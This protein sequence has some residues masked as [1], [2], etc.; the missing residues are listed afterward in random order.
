MDR[1]F[2]IFIMLFIVRSTARY[3]SS[4]DIEPFMMIEG[5]SS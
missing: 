2:S 1:Q 4:L 5:H 3:D